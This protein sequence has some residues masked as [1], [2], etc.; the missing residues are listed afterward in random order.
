MKLGFIVEYIKKPY[1]IAALKEHVDR[2]LQVGAFARAEPV[3]EAASA[4]TDS[5]ST[6][7][8]EAQSGSHE[9][10]AEDGEEDDKKEHATDDE[11]E[12]DPGSASPFNQEEAR[13]VAGEYKRLIDA[14]LPMTDVSIISP[15]RAQVKLITHLLQ[16]DE[17]DIEKGLGPRIDSVD[18]FQGQENEAVIVSLVR[19]NLTGSIGFL[20]DT[21]RMNVAL[22]RARR[23]LIVV[24]DSATLSTL[25]FYEKFI[26]YAESVDGY[27]SAWKYVQ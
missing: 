1:D 16:I 27:E 7:S 5:E 11:E 17:W 22:T 19:S 14:G 18:A 8:T 9:G 26:R 12:F 10:D 25:P 15:Y 21:R 24:G 6:S 2:L 3:A 13:L 20:G 23:K 4:A